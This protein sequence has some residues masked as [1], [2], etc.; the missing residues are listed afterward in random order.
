MSRPKSMHYSRYS[1]FG[2]ATQFL[3]LSILLYGTEYPIVQTGSAVPALSPPSLLFTLCLLSGVQGGKLSKP[4]CY[5][6][7][8]KHCSTQQQFTCYSKHCFSHK[9]ETQHHTGRYEDNTIP[10]RPST[11]MHIKICA[12]WK[13]GNAYSHGC[14]HLYTSVCQEAKMFPDHTQ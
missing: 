5:A 10:A 6:N 12:C 11:P 14:I 2:M 1:Y 4:W 3:L 7:M 13:N 8:C 9:F